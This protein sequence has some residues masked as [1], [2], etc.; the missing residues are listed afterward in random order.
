MINKFDNVKAMN[1]KK[2]ASFYKSRFI[3]SIVVAILTISSLFFVVSCGNGS[4]SIEPMTDIGAVGMEFVNGTFKTTVDTDVKNY[5]LDSKLVVAEGATIIYSKS[6]DFLTTVNGRS[7]ELNPGDNLVF[8]KVIDSNGFEKVHKVNVYRK[9][10]FTIT[11][12]TNGGTV[13]E[14]VQVKEGTALI[15]P[16][17][18]VKSGYTFVKWSYDF[19]KPISA[20]QTVKAEWKANQYE[21]SISNG[22]DSSKTVTYGENYSLEDQIPSQ[23]GYRFL[24]WVRIYEENGT[25]IKVPFDTTGQFNFA[26]NI[27]VD[28]VLE[29]IEYLINYVVAPGA[30]NNN[31]TTKFTVE[32]V[33]DLLDAEWK[34][35]EKRFVGWYTSEDYAESSKIS[36]ISN[37][38]EPI[39]LWAKFEDVIFTSNVTCNVDAQYVDSA[40]SNTYI[41]TYK[42]PYSLFVPVAKK[43]YVFKGWQYKGEKID[44]E[45]VWSYKYED[46]MTI[47]AVFEATNNSINYILPSEE[48]DNS[49]NPNNYTIEDGKVVLEAPKFGNHIF[50]GWYT[51]PDFT[52]PI[53]ELN[54]DTVSEQMTIYSKWTYVSCVQF[55]VDGEVVD[56]LSETY[57]FG[58]D[59][60]LPRP[61]KAGSYFVGWYYGDT[62]VTSGVWKYKED[63]VLVA[64]WV[65]STYAINYVING[66]AQN[67]ENPNP[68]SFDLYAEVIQLQNPKMGNAIFEGWY[69]DSQYQN[70]VT[71][72]DTS[73]IGDVTLYAKWKTVT[74]IY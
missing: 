68:A 39:T 69:S 61:T 45:G 28:A 54:I 71:E 19:S 63:V 18:T 60:E 72:I 53:T 40:I 22:I 16:P 10:I 49:I 3:L 47:E 6:E 21:I 41:F 32:S 43:G 20:S 67:V 31:A 36:T 24:G 48:I 55:E 46:D 57:I 51:D 8:A 70:L 15:A 30:T 9:Q 44:L 58:E 17:Q 26:S 13:I 56:E 59:C 50:G 27:K 64:N 35:D 1:G 73:I 12:D 74:V 7:I 62:L 23:R 11:F 37:M 29:P 5:D 34:D 66:N 2:K 4:D 52:N 25:T 65:A 14:P 38:A 33:V 42:S